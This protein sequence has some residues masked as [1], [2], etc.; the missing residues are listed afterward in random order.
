[1]AE[2]SMPTVSPVAS[3]DRP[4]ARASSSSD[5]AAALRCYRDEPLI[6]RLFTRGR[7]WLCP[8]RAVAA[9]VP[10]DARVLDVGCG[11]GLFVNLLAT[12]SAQRRIVGAEPDAQRV[13]TARRCSRGFENVSYIVGKVQDVNDGPYD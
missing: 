1:M 7:H 4:A 11:Y 6:L 9:E 3:S 10:A 13:E 8:M 2:I 5:M 12:G